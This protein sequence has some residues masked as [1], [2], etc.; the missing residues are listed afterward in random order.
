VEG[1]TALLKL[2][3]QKYRRAAFVA[4]GEHLSDYP[5]TQASGL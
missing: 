5:T 1:V 3:G 2:E 4:G